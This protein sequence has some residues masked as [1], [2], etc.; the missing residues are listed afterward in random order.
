MPAFGN[1]AG[2]VWSGPDLNVVLDRS[3][4]PGPGTRPDPFDQ[5]EARIAGIGC[6]VEVMNP[7][8]TG[9]PDGAGHLGLLETPEHLRAEAQRWGQMARQARD[10]AMAA[11][12]YRHLRSNAARAAQTA[13]D[14]PTPSK[15]NL[16]ASISTQVAE[17]AE[18]LA[19]VLGRTQDLA[20]LPPATVI[21]FLAPDGWHAEALV[22]DGE[23]A[24]GKPLLRVEGAESEDRARSDLRDLA[25]SSDV[26]EAARRADFLGTRMRAA[27]QAA[28][29]GADRDHQE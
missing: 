22:H 24:I 3:W 4:A 9:R 6:S 28:L 11:A 27:A 13:S 17:S 23:G 8:D 2:R 5:V 25:A 19:Q 1:S 26:V 29:G 15:L 7:G 21:T 14:R 16:S 18:R 10:A 12:S 20:A